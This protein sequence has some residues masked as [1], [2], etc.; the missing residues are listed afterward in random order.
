MSKFIYV[1]VVVPTG[2]C[3][4]GN[5]YVQESRSRVHMPYPNCG[6]SSV[7]EHIGVGL[8]MQFA[9]CADECTLCHSSQTIVR[10]CVVNEKLVSTKRCFK[11]YEYIFLKL[12]FFFLNAVM[13]PCFRITVSVVRGDSGNR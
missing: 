6:S 13:T 10:R 7:V 4:R 11:T 2:K 8:M 5:I 3:H 9:I 12:L 1:Q